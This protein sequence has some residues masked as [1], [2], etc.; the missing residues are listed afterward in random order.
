M[1]GE[2]T[3][4][5]PRLV[6]KTIAHVVLKEGQ[7]PGGQLCLAFT[8]GTYYEFYSN[9]PLCGAAGIDAGGLAAVLAYGAGHFEVVFRC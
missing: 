5:L 9:A 6:G 2:I 7:S 8:D 1:N 3:T 4:V